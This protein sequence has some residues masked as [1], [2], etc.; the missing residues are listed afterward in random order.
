MVIY[1]SKK[2]L[3]SN[4]VLNEREFGVRIISDSGHGLLD[5]LLTQ[6]GLF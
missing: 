2:I 6:I 1:F 4:F 3:K 5:F